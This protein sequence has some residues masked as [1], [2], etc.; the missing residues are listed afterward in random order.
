M[1]SPRALVRHIGLALRAIFR[2][3]GRQLYFDLRNR[4]RGVDLEYVSIGDLGFSADVAHFH[5]QSGGDSLR[6]VFAAIPIP[7]GSVALDFGSGK[8]GAIISLHQLPFAEIRGVELSEPLVAVAKENMARLRLR[9]ARFIV[10]DATQYRDLD[11]VT[12]IYMYNPFPCVVMAG[13]LRN[14]EASLT[15]APRQLHV[16]YRNPICHELL[17]GSKWLTPLSRFTRDGHEWRIYRSRQPQSQ[18]SI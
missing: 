3:E 17:E 18:A 8:G 2:G 1:A 16:V 6:A 5:S 10:S 11:A 14:I 9:R 13:V 7:K 4:L 15:A 12:H